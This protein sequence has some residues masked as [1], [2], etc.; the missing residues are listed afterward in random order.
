MRKPEQRVIHIDAATLTSTLERFRN[1]EYTFAGKSEDN[2]MWLEI[3]LNDEE[4]ELAA[5]KEIKDIVGKHYS[6][7]ARIAIETHC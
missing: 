3:S 5:L 1:K 7:F 4:R 2:D 6:P